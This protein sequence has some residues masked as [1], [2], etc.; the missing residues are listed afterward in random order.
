MFDGAKASDQETARERE[1]ER[2]SARAT[3]R[4]N[5][6]SRSVLL[7]DWGLNL[8]KREIETVGNKDV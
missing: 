2:A 1:T 8:S 4:K 5:I 6:V 3:K 7:L